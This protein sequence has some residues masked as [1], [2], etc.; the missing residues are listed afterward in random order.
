MVVNGRPVKRAKRRVTA[1][2]Y[3]FFSFPSSS[4]SS[5]ADDDLDGPFRSNVQVFLSRH[6]RLLPPPSILPPPSPAGHL[7]TWRIGFGLGEWAVGGG[8]DSL[9]L[10]RSPTADTVEL[11]VVEEDVLRSKSVYCD[12]CRV[13]GWSGH[14]VCRKRYHFIIRNSANL[15]SDSHYKCPFCGSLV[16]RVDSSCP[17][18][19]Y[20]ITAEV[21]ENWPHHQLEDPT[22]LLHG[23]VHA[24]GYGHLL[25][26]NGRDGGSARLTGSEIM[27]FWDRLCKMLHV[28]YGI[29]S[30]IFSSVIWKFL[31]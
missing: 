11:D 10:A 1:D 16:Q 17:S 22:H 4:S 27:D 15:L 2:L 18:C 28:R 5:D 13:V 26:V 31:L 12:Q 7:L 30:F 9:S 20:D 25:R 23:V 21:L 14:P 29:H 6:A 3:D 19:N 24:N 8:D